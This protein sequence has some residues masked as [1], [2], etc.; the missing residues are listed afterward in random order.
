MRTQ[1]MIRRRPGK[2]YFFLNIHRDFK[3]WDIKW[4]GRVKTETCSRDANVMMDVCSDENGY[5]K[6]IGFEP[7]RIRIPDVFLFFFDTLF[8][9]VMPC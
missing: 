3:F 2:M 8:C 6:E 7:S 1:R 9:I 4:I 5:D